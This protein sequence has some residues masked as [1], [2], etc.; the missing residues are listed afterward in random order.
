MN[1]RNVPMKKVVKNRFSMGLRLKTECSERLRVFVIYE[2]T[3]WHLRKCG[4]DRLGSCMPTKGLPTR[5]LCRSC[6]PIA[7]QIL[8]QDALAEI[9]AEMAHR[10]GLKPI[11]KNRVPASLTTTPRTENP[12]PRHQVRGNTSRNP[13]CIPHTRR[14]RKDPAPQTVHSVRMFCSYPAAVI[15]HSPVTWDPIALLR[16]CSLCNATTIPFPFNA[17]KTKRAKL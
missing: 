15:G 17:P 7:A 6:I 9:G 11:P 14:V 12:G 3:S 8:S 13:G 4:S 10:R 1:A 5:Q 2:N 16:V